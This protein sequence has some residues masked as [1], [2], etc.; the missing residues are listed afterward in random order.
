MV[1]NTGGVLANSHTA[2]GALSFRPVVKARPGVT[3]REVAKLMVDANASSVLIDEAGVRMLTERDLA[4]ALVAGFGP[5]TPA[6]NVASAAPVW[7]TPTTRVGEAADLMLH[8]EIRHLVVLAADGTAV[9]VLSMRDIF[10]LLL[11]E[12]REGT[13]GPTADASRRV[14]STHEDI[15]PSDA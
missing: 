7:A 9:G 2:L 12:A 4:H 3:L 5:D 11:R 13:F 1:K 6:E 8:H 10:P 15:G 14:H